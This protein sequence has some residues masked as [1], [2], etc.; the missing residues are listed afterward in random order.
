VTAASHN[1]PDLHSV[2][3]DATAASKFRR[4]GLQD[5]PGDRLAG[6]RRHHATAGGRGMTATM[7]ELVRSAAT[8]S[9]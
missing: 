6:R 9:A 4:G 5:E 1:P 7:V 2:R 8:V 3:W